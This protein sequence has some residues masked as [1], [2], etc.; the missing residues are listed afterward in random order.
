MKIIV[1]VFNQIEQ[2]LFCFYFAK[3]FIMNRCWILSDDFSPSIEVII[4]FLSLLIYWNTVVNFQMLNHP[5]FPKISHDMLS[6]LYVDKFFHDMLS[7]LYINKCFHDMLSYLYIDKFDWLG[8]CWRFAC[9]EQRESHATRSLMTG[10]F[11][12]AWCFQDS[13]MV[14]HISILIPFITK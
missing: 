11:H 13:S 1:V 9:S 14:W 12:L 4:V 10:F 2:V 3:V 5:C 7:Y 6:Y 8:F